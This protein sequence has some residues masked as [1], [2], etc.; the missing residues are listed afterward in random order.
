[1]ALNLDLSLVRHGLLMCRRLARIQERVRSKPYRLARHRKR[2]I[3]LAIL[4]RRAS[5]LDA[6]RGLGVLSS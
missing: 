1:M 3:R 4:R 2:P 5:L 6:G